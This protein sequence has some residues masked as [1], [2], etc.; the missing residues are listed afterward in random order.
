MTPFLRGKRALASDLP[1]FERL[2]VLRLPPPGEMLLNNGLEITV[3]ELSGAGFI[4][5]I[6]TLLP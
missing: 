5:F 1:E 2:L 6:Q 3:L 4:R